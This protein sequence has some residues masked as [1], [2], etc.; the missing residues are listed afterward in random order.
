MGWKDA[1]KTRI[2]ANTPPHMVPNPRLSELVFA[3]AMGTP[4]SP[5]GMY[6]AQITLSMQNSRYRCVDE[7]GLSWL[8]TRCAFLAFLFF[9]QRDAIEIVPRDLFVRCDAV[10]MCDVSDKALG[11]GWANIK[12]RI[13]R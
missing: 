12:R 3:V 4:S 5:R 13:Y 9:Y 10:Q 11:W 6:S 1:R 2:P 8:I 7:Q